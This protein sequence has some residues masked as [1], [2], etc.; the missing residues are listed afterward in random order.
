[1][2]AQDLGDDAS[3]RVL[4]EE[5]VAL[6]RQLGDRD[7]LSRCLLGLGFMAL[8]NQGE[9][10]AAHPYFMESFEVSVELGQ[11]PIYSLQ[12]LS[13][14]AA[15]MNRPARALRLAGAAMALR[16]VRNM[17]P[18]PLLRAK[19]ERLLEAAWAALPGEAGRAIWSEGR[20]MT[21]EQLTAYALADAD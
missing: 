19:H 13:S 7:D 1:L 8:Y 16:E 21:P 18:S 15:A 12:G 10:E 5:G 14:A 6:G 20:A 11:P 4:L 2:A 3:A 9:T 17:V